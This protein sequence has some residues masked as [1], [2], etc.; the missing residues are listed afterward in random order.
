MVGWNFDLSLELFYDFE[1]RSVVFKFMLRLIFFL[2]NFKIYSLF[3]F[4]FK[5][6]VIIFI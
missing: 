4:V 1:V 2:D 6:L 3:I 5:D